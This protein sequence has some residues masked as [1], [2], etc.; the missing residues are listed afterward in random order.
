MKDV[1]LKQLRNSVTGTLETY[2]SF[3]GMVWTNIRRN[4]KLQEYQIKLA[5]I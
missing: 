5:N 3:D 4:K 2:Y 1:K